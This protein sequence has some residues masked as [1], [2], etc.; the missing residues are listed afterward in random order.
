VGLKI[1]N[2]TAGSSSAK[3]ALQPMIGKFN[4]EFASL[5]FDVSS[6]GTLDS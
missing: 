6:T 1:E 5:G 4:G 2:F 3:Q